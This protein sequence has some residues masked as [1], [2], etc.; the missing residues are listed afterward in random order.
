MRL[1][2]KRRKRPHSGEWGVVATHSALHFGHPS[3]VWITYWMNLSADSQ[4]SM[5]IDPDRSVTISPAAWGRARRAFGLPRR[6]LVLDH[7]TAAHLRQVIPGH[8]DITIAPADPR[9]T[10]MASSF[11]EL[12]LDDLDILPF[13]DPRARA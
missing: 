3:P 12:P 6:I 11:D 4:M 1:P 2:K 9:L 10:S 5:E 8:V 7:D 13:P